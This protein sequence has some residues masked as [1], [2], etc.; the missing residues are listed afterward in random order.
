M[1]VRVN[2]RV[3]IS[4][5]VCVCLCVS[6]CI[7]ERVLVRV[8]PFRMW[9]RRTV[10]NTAGVLYGWIPLDDIVCYIFDIIFDKPRK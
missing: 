2:A 5:C 6:V 8:D 1:S 3:C 4:V 7:L 9:R 10:N